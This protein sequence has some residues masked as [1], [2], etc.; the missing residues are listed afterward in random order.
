M[1]KPHGVPQGS[2]LGPLLFNIFLNDIFF[3]EKALIANYADDNTVIAVED[4]LSLL[5]TLE[6]ETYTVLNWFGFNEMK[7]NDSKCHLIVAKENKRDYDSKHFVY[8]MNTLLEDEH[9]VKLLGIFIDNELNFETHV[10]NLVKQGNQKLHAIMR[11][12]KFLSEDKLRLC[13]KT[14]I[15]SLFNYCPLIWMFHSRR[16]NNKI[17][18]LHERALRVVYYDDNL[19]FEELLKKDNSFTIHERNLQK[20]AIE[21]YKAKNN[22][23]RIPINDLF[24]QGESLA[25]RRPTDW[26]I[27]KVQSEKYGK[28]TVRYMGPITWNLLP[29][30]IRE[31]QSLNSFKEMII[32]WKPIGCP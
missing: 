13:M 1:E 21:M 20:L 24:I 2:I 25:L 6:K 28:E 3:I 26:V 19:T 12:S 32:E 16:I 18:K 4:I 31:C 17:N 29:S 14:F 27:P 30:K 9:A 7:A 23:S 8:L 22:I 11:I 15:E 10:N 5:K